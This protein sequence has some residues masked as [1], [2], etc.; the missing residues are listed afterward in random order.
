MAVGEVTAGEAVLNGELSNGVLNGH[1]NGHTNGHTN[2]LV[3]PERPS[4][5]IKVII[6][7]AGFGGLTAAIECH[8]QGHTVEMY[9]SFREL[10]V[11]GDIISFGSNAGRI[12]RRWF[13]SSGDR[14][15]DRLD[16]LSIKLQNYG[17]NIHKY[18]GELIMNQ[19]T[20]PSDPDAPVFNGHRGEIHATV[21]NYVKDEL[22]IP[23]HLGC[24]ITK[25]FETETEAGIVL[26]TG[27]RAT[28]DVVIGADGVRSKARE[29]V[30]GYVDA[31][32]S[33]GYAV[34]RAWFPN[35]DMLADPETRRFCENG[36]TFNGW[37]G[38][39]VH[40]LFSTIKNG[41]DCC[42][43]L[44]H[45][46]EHDIE[47]SWSFPGKLEDVYKVFEGWD[48]LCKRIVSKTP[49]DKLVDWKLVYRDPLPRWV[50]DGGRTM[51]L[52]DSA[53]P[54][55]PTSAQGATQAMEDGVT[56]A[57]C[58]REAGKANI[59]AAT[60]AFQ[61]IRY[62]RVKAVQKTGE[63]TRDMWHKADWDKVKANPESM[64]MPREDWILGHDSEKHAEDVIAETLRKFS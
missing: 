29:L 49:E 54:F 15:S 10:K 33:S 35:T 36:D 28:A 23:I 59:T 22:A 7:G 41:S 16:K 47:E 20:P 31:P 1:V 57:I 51:L 21:F 30:L 56:I 17:F 62:D 9:E 61:D 34:F 26:D 5:G 38:P 27:E 50:S 46:D 6:V 60:R 39:D 45:V 19:R 40:F 53:H 3:A 4:S 44:T 25:Y 63:T 42:W 18:T 64:A 12:Y 24:R 58:L 2:G 8:R 14:I 32:K 13:T 37:I 55:L 52:G 48:P 43:V 11:L